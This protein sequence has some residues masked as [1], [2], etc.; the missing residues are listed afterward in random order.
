MLGFKPDD[1][2]TAADRQRRKDFVRERLATRYS[3]QWNNLFESMDR[4]AFQ[5]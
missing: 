3:K 2:H 1:S 5:R 4:F